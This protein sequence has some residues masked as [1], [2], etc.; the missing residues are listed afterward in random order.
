MLA[1]A[2]TVG[3]LV[4]GKAVRDAFFL[5]QFD[6]RLLPRMMVVAALASFLAVLVVS[7]AI[8]RFGPFRAMPVMFGAGFL[9]LLVHAALAAHVPRVAAVALYVHMASFGST[10]VSGFWSLVNERYDP[11]TAKRVVARLAGGATAGGLV[12]SAVVWRAANHVPVLALL[13]VMAGLN[14]ACLAGVLGMARGGPAAV[15]GGTGAEG[16]A[17]NVFEGLHVLQRAPYLRQLGL[18]VGVI[19]MASALMDYLLGARASAAF[20][21]GPELLSFFA[22]FQLTIGL[23]SFV[24]L[25]LLSRP[26]LK[27]LGLAGTVALLPGATLVLGVAALSLPTLLTS[28]ALRGCEAVLQNSLFRSSYELM[29]TPIAAAR[30]RATKLIIDVAFDRV[31]TA[32]GGAFAIALVWL[33]PAETERLVGGTVLLL[34]AAALWLAR[35]LHTGYVKALEESLVAGSVR[36]D[37]GE[38]VDSTTW[39][40]ITQT[41]LQLDRR[42]ILDEI[43]RLRREQQGVVERV[44]QG[45]ADFVSAPVE[46]AARSLRSAH[47]AGEVAARVSQLLLADPR[48]IRSILTGPEP[49]TTWMVPHVIPMLGVN[50]LRRDAMQA[51]RNVAPL[52]TGQLLDALLDPDTSLVVR[53]RLPRVLRGCS[54]QRA[55]EGLLHGLFDS[56]FDIRYQCGLALWS[57]TAQNHDIRLAKRTVLRAVA[58]EVEV[59]R[60][61]WETQATDVGDS[62]GETLLE[63]VLADRKNRCLA[64]VFRILGLVLEREPLML[65]FRALHAHDAR[66]RGTSLEYLENVLPTDIRDRLWPFLDDSRPARSTERPRQEILAELLSSSSNLSVEAVRALRRS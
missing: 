60:S 20:S 12:A 32:A 26:A 38:A 9:L 11:H 58:L 10:T 50:E 53:R 57:V 33:L 56:R 16:H 34:S 59:D 64:H 62:G 55:A 3:Q 46:P 47:V 35:R 18:L 45:R 52:V 13:L 65:A 43:E 28:A 51:L 31:G 17:G 25:S 15:A 23:L 8:A 37:E 44:E 14:I 42:R 40:T 66:L 63:D 39:Q 1:A 7:R 48:Q 22:L 21:T 61:V 30:K 2:A 4:M 41:N 24:A 19:A 5:S 49:L 54:T 6:V 27:S 29:F 36:L